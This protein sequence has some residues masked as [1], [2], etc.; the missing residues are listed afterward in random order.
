[1]APVP[2]GERASMQLGSEKG[3]DDEA[4]F[5]GTLQRNHVEASSMKIHSGD[6][7]IADHRLRLFRSD[8]WL[9]RHLEALERDLDVLAE[10]PLAVMELYGAAL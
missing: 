8:V 9:R 7:D 1:M 2:A 6:L 3:L 5:A 10:H 4:G